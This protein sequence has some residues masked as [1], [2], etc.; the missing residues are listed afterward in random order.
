MKH[1]YLSW[2]FTEESRLPPHYLS[3]FYRLRY[4]ESLLAPSTLSG[5][6]ETIKHSF[7]LPLLCNECWWGGILMVGSG[8]TILQRSGICGLCLS[9]IIFACVYKCVWVCVHLSLGFIYIP[10]MI[11]CVWWLE[12]WWCVCVVW[13]A[14]I[15]CQY[16]SSAIVKYFLKKSALLTFSNLL[17]KSQQTFSKIPIKLAH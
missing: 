5:H 12:W 9:T 16:L 3:N 6:G 13:G 8:G 17:P 14:L 1:D 7:R 4:N 2:K 11:F 15:S 10:I